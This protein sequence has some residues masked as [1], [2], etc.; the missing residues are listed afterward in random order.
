MSL[1]PGQRDDLEAIA[2]K[3][4]VKLAFVVRSALTEF[5]HNHSDKQ[6]RLAFPDLMSS[7]GEVRDGT[8]AMGE[9]NEG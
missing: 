7:S 4:G 1:A 9:E 5:I 8:A 6:L 2:A 3:N